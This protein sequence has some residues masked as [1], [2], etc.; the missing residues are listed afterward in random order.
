MQDLLNRDTFC[1]IHRRFPV[2][3][4]QKLLAI[5]MTFDLEGNVTGQVYPRKKKMTACDFQEFAFKLY[6]LTLLIFH[7]ILSHKHRRTVKV[8]FN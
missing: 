3:A 5:V 2:C 7:N 6:N 1:T 8:F 4:V